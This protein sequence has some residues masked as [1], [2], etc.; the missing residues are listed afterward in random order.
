MPGRSQ[1][2]SE[3]SRTFL[4]CASGFKG[5]PL[6]STRRDRGFT[7]VEILIVVTV[8][9]MLVAVTLGALQKSQESARAEKTKALIAKINDII[10]Q[11][12]ESY[13]TRRLPLNFAGYTP[14]Q[15]AELRMMAIRDLM[16]R[17]MP[18]RWSDVTYDVPNNK[19]PLQAQDPYDNSMTPALSALP[20]PALQ[21]AYYAKYTNG[22]ALL[23]PD[24]ENAKCLYLTVMTNNPEARALFSADEIADVDGD[25]FFEFVDGW[26]HPI[27]WLRWAPGFTPYSDIQIDDTQNAAGTAIGLDIHHDPF[28]PRGVEHFDPASDGTNKSQPKLKGAY[29][30]IPLIFAGVVGKDQWGYDDYG[31][32]GLSPNDQKVGTAIVPTFDPYNGNDNSTPAFCPMNASGVRTGNPASV[33]TSIGTVLHSVPITN[34]HMEQR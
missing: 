19:M 27:G 12:Y 18:E 34:H 6:H 32:Q 9:G 28:D 31:I 5:S 33:Q 24:H 23:K 11:R 3:P 17:E 21:Q 2:F 25:G 20:C 30:L 14:K 8:I 26:G 10:M 16:R 29:N 7:L 1:H 4:A 22:K 13:K 15:A